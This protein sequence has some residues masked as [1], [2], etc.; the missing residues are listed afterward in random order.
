MVDRCGAQPDPELGRP[1][2]RELLRVQAQAEARGDRRSA[3]AL[4]GREVVEASIREDVHE[5]GEAL[6]GD[7]R[8]HLVRDA[9]RVLSCRRALGDRV[10]AKERCHDAYR[11]L[12][13]DAPNDAEVA[14]LFLQRQAVT[15]LAL[16]RRRSGGQGGPQALLAERLE[17]RVIGR[18]RGSHRPQDSA[19]GVGGSLEARRG[20]IR[21]VSGEDRMGVAVD[22][23]RRHERGAEVHRLVAIGRLARIAD[24]RDPSIANLDRPR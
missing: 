2:S 24:P 22:E 11:Q 12:I 10:G 8:D 23:A 1:G 18:A 15:G 17:R 6:R 20:F 16:H 13:G 19:A 9:L 21:A 4:G 3:D 7:R 14:Q 5:V